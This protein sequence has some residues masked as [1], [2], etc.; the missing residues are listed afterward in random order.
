[1]RYL[2]TGVTSFAAMMNCGARVN[3]HDFVKLI[4]GA[5]ASVGFAALVFGPLGFGLRYTDQLEQRADAALG[6]HGLGQVDVAVVRNPALQRDLVLSGSVDLRLQQ[7]AVDIVRAVPGAAEVRWASAGSA[8]SER[9]G[10]ST[11]Y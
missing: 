5:S 8:A 3:R 7:Q 9:S 2:A 11:R 1:M 6:A 10:L 4:V